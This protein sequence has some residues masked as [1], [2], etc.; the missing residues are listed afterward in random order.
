MGAGT[1]KA[2]VKGAAVAAG[3]VAGYVAADKATEFIKN[4]VEKN[5]QPRQFSAD[6]TNPVLGQI[7]QY[8]TAEQSDKQGSLASKFVPAGTG[9]VDIVEKYRWTLSNR[10]AVPFIQL[11]EYEIT[12]ALLK[13]QFENFITNRAA[14]AGRLGS[15]A[16]SGGGAVGILDLYKGLV[17]KD[18]PTNFIY[19]FPYFSKTAFELQSNWDQMGDVTDDIGKLPGKTGQTAAATA[20]AIEAIGGLVNSA[21]EA[22]KLKSG[23]QDKPKIF[24]SHSDRTIQ[25]KFSLFN[26]QSQE[27]WKMNREFIQVFMTQNLFNKR[28]YV[29]G[30]PPVFYEVFIPGQYYSYGSTVSNIRIENLGNIHYID[31]IIVPDAYEIEISLTEM[32]KP[33]RNQFEALFT[34]EA[35]NNVTT[36]T[37]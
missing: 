28:D 6:W 21:T 25:I 26:T 16:G 1:I 10:K 24:A 3:A 30:L 2:V 17:V 4:T 12:Q 13:R 18:N 15:I 7:A 33:S 32:V 8:D 29:S 35:K 31:D 22:A 36:G 9:L 11:K 37:R 19:R 5:R 20:D 14:D 23:D 34:G 27:D